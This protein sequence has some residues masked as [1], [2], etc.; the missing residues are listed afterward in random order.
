M[1]HAENWAAGL[2][3]PAYAP[4]DET[5]LRVLDGRAEV[6]SEDRWKHIAR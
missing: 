3:A 5:A 4:D 2:N 1:A 6:V